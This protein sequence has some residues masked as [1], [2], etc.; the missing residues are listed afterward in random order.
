MKIKL[1]Y[2]APCSGKSTYVK[3]H[4]GNHDFIWDFDKLLMA[5]T[6]QTGQSADGHPMAN[7]IIDLRK[8]IIEE[9]Q[10]RPSVEN[11]YITC[12]WITDK[13]K[14]EVEGLDTEE[15]FIEA[16]KEECFQRLNSDENW[17]IVNK[18]DRKSEG[19][20][21]NIFK[22][23]GRKKIDGGMRSFAVIKALNILKK[24]KM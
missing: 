20:E 9:V 13:L 11:L 3:E 19:R 17:I 2:G 5:C 18:V 15:I 4:A 23:I 7:F 16:T 22:N 8:K 10:S 1:V 6:N 14:S 21:K 24:R 12:L